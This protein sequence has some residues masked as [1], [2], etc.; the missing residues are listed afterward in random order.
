[1]VLAVIIF[2]LCVFLPRE[3]DIL[4]ALML[5]IKV[6]EGKRTIGYAEIH[7]DELME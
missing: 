5:V 3:A 2:A 1:M 6:I 4:P 7:G